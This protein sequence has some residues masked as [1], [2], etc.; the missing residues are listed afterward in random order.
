[1]APVHA[2]ALAPPRRRPAPKADRI[3][4]AN[5]RI[6]E[7]HRVTA[8]PVSI[9]WRAELRFDADAYPV[10]EEIVRAYYRRDAALRAAQASRADLTR[11]N[12][13]FRAAMQ[14]TAHG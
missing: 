10:E 4:L 7:L 11:L 9:D 13:A 14:E 1:M 12:K 6:A 2:I 3:A 8:G 5:S